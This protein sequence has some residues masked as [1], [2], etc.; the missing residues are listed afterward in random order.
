VK[1]YYAL[2]A[3]GSVTSVALAAPAN[4]TVSGSPVTTSG[5]LT[6]AW[7][8]L[9]TN[10]LLQATSASAVSSTLTPSG[11]T[12]IGVNTV[13]AATTLTLNSATIAAGGN[14]FTFAGGS[15]I[16]DSTGSITVQ[17]AGS[18]AAIYGGSN[19]AGWLIENAGNTSGTIQAALLSTSTVSSIGLGIAGYTS[20]ATSGSNV[21]VSIADTYNQSSGT[22]ANTDLKIK[23]TETA[24]GSGNQYLIDAIT[25]STDE[26]HVTDA[27]AGFFNGAVVT[28]SI[29][30]TSG[31]LTGLT[32]LAIRDTSAAFDVT[33]AATSSVTLT[34]GR[35]LT[36]D[37]A[38]ASRTLKM[39]GNATLNQDVSTA[40][41]PSF[42]AI[43][44]PGAIGGTTPAAG[45]FTTLGT[46][47]GITETTAGIATTSTPGLID[48]NTTASTSGATVQYSPSRVLISH[49]WNTTS[50]AADNY[51]QE[52]EELRPTSAAT[53]TSTL[54][55][56]FSRSASSTPTYSDQM[57]LTSAGVLSVGSI[58]GTASDGAAPIKGTNTND[59]ASAGYVGEYVT[60]SVARD[61]FSFSSGTAANVVSISLTAGDWIVAGNTL[62]TVLSGTEAVTRAQS[63]IST[64][65]ATLPSEVS[66]SYWA[67]AFPLN[68]DQDFTGNGMTRVSLASTT[69]VY[70]VAQINWTGGVGVGGGGSIQ[71]WRIR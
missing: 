9:T 20:T 38:N 42:T 67:M 22:A 44:S 7:S 71:A 17:G 34:A 26:F 51:L 54:Y 57:S 32:A 36:I 48:Q 37:V 45:N 52:R 63:G 4:F 25:G 18:F 64:T 21:G 1:G 13:T 55:W 46:T 68:P 24:I 47:S 31:T 5:T 61:N 59:S 56:S 29:Q 14:T 30:A 69:T 28:S 40:G 39:T 58:L 6:F 10:G 41:S 8:G 35:T 70:V 53:P 15:S 19:N 3:G 49:A 43:P 33:L 11:L 65:S 62:F 66:P 23:R 16:G 2:V 50:T 60:A 27:G 12:S